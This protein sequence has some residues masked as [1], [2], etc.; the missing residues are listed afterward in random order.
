[1]EVIGIAAYDDGC[2]EADEDT[3]DILLS[4][5]RPLM[6]LLEFLYSEAKYSQSSLSACET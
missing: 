3:A 1:M 5:P 4:L 6:P 2:V